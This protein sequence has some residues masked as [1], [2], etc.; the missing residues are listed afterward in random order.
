MLGCLPLFLGSIA[1]G[2]PSREVTPEVRTPSPSQDDKCAHDARRGV[3]S[4][5]GPHIPA[6]PVRDTP[7]DGHALHEEAGQDEARD[8]GAED[9]HVRQ[10]V[11]IWEAAVVEVGPPRH[12]RAAAQACAD[13]RIGL[14]PGRIL[15]WRPKTSAPASRAVQDTR[16][17]RTPGVGR[18]HGV[19]AAGGHPLTLTVRAS[20][21]TVRA[22]SSQYSS[23][24]V[25]FHR[26]RAVLCFSSCVW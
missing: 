16:A 24:F 21:A 5:S 22:H 15:A 19:R 1:V 23:F 13:V 25:F 10:G 6:R 11:D 7:P 2:R 12:R 17:L 4:R 8:E 26:A 20:S 3:R 9:R 14:V 18:D